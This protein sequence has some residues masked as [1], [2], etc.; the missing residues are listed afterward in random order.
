MEDEANILESLLYD[1]GEDVDMMDVEEGEMLEQTDVSQT[2]GGTGNGGEGDSKT[3]DN[4]PTTKKKRR[5]RKR[6]KPANGSRPAVSIDRRLKEKKS[7][8]VYTAVG[9]L[10]LEVLSDLVTEVGAIQ[11]CGGQMT[12]DGKRRRTGGGILWNILKTREP[13][14]YR[15]IMKKATEFEKQFKQPKPTRPAAAKNTV[16]VSNETAQA[17]TNAAP[18]D[19]SNATAHAIS[20]E[21]PNVSGLENDNGETMRRSVHDRIRVPV[22]YDDL[23][24]DDDPKDRCT[25]DC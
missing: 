21:T 8:M 25:L 18:D 23:I 12:S 2:C 13:A 16:G 20:N 9:I 15:E 7:Y 24:Q 14:A 1:E 3:T 22:S 4:H 5:N 10:G 19:L 11:S 6:K 17:A